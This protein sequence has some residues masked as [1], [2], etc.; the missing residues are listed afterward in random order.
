[1]KQNNNKNTKAYES[2]VLDELLSLISPEELAR[3]E[4]RMILAAK[5][6]DAM[7]AKGLGKKQFAELMGQRPSVITKWLS[8][9]HTLTDIQRGL[10][11]QLLALEEK[12]IAQIRYQANVNVIALMS[13]KIPNSTGGCS[14][15]MSLKNKVTVPLS[16]FER[17]T[18]CA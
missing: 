12:P 15:G 13:S 17:Q 4:S 8:G 5:I 10:N 9:G 3:T 18:A 16:T 6:F 7:V 11:I 2:T 14:F 1:M